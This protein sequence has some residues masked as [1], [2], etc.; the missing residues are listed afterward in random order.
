[1]TSTLVPISQTDTGALSN[2]T[3]RQNNYAVDKTKAIQKK[4]DACSRPCVY[5]D[6]FGNYC[7]QF[8]TASFE[9]MRNL[10]LENVRL[11]RN[12]KSRH[13]DHFKECDSSPDKVVVKDIF[14][15]KNWQAVS[16]K[17][18]PSHTGAC[19]FTLCLHRTTSQITVNGK[20]Y[21]T[22][23]EGL[24]L[25]ADALNASPE[26]QQANKQYKSILSSLMT[27]Q[28][29]T[30]APPK[31]ISDTPTVEQ[32]G[33]SS[34]SNALLGLA[35][36]CSPE[37]LSELASL[38]PPARDDDS[39]TSEDSPDI[40]NICMQAVTDEQNSLECSTC[41]TWVHVMCDASITVTQFKQYCKK[42]NKDLTY[43]C[44]TCSLLAD[45]QAPTQPAQDKRLP[46]HADK[47]EAQKAQSV[48]KH[49][50]DKSPVAAP[51]APQEKAQSPQLP[52]QAEPLPQ[53]TAPFPPPPPPMYL[54]PPMY[55]AG[56]R[57]QGPRLPT[58][59]QGSLQ[60]PSSRSI[61][62]VRLQVPPSR[63]TS[64]GRPGRPRKDQAATVISQPSTVYLPPVN[65]P[66]TMQHLQINDDHTRKE[67]LLK[68]QEK[69]LNHRDKLLKE[70]ELD[71]RN[72]VERVASQDAYIRTL[73]EKLKTQE[74]VIESTYNKMINQ[75]PSA[76]P[77][78]PQ[79]PPAQ[80]S[81]PNPCEQQHSHAPSMP[82]YY[83]MQLNQ[84][85]LQY[86]IHMKALENRVHTVELLLQHNKPQQ[87]PP[88]QPIVYYITQPPPAIPSAIPPTVPPTVPPPP[89]FTHRP[90]LAYPPTVPPTPA[91]TPTVPPTPAYPPTVQPTSA[92][93]PTVPPTPAYPPPV[94]PPAFSIQTRFTA[95][96]PKAQWLSNVLQQERRPWQHQPQRGHF[97]Q[98]PRQRNAQPKAK[99]RSSPTSVSTAPLIDLDT[100]IT[101]KP[102]D[103]QDLL[104]DINTE[105]TST[106]KQNLLLPTP[107]TTPAIMQKQATPQERKCQPAPSTE[108]FLEL[109]GLHHTTK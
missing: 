52:S 17:V 79:Q 55:T 69:D 57:P 42:R 31:A 64:G 3:V 43:T 7:F 16:S 37:K 62:G 77:L 84:M 30:T 25:L 59:Q 101:H 4:L 5:E 39:T 80:A 68:S 26:I 36:Q 89:Q 6:K 81:P 50:A 63:S 102:D 90:N 28:D 13:I 54:Q 66:P 98:P 24:I 88:Q 34:P 41:S 86:D 72:T 95:A 40:C 108:H 35:V 91:Y 92:Y 1:M 100:V 51:H 65:E 15:I 46:K 67:K 105:S 44:P 8:N 75:Q 76:H 103:L 74:A 82:L 97:G 87:L 49:T 60:V 107:A 78:P 22:A 71:F 83:Q 10:V 20:D 12:E 99:G 47:T 106:R 18:F 93:P 48:N 104:P 29:D 11:P 73:E 109:T 23:A 56:M 33:V 9:M 58:P 85:Q 27:D 19:A 53:F 14:K 70:K 38:S 21:K 96:P 32:R 61:S 2:T 94:P 45:D